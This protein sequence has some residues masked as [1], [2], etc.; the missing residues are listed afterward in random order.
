MWERLS[1][2][3]VLALLALSALMGCV[4]NL[5]VET[6]IDAGLAGEAR[7]AEYRLGPSDKI[8]LIIYGEPD[9]SGE[10]SINAH[11][12]LSLPLLGEVDAKGLTIDELRMQVAAGFS[13]GYLNDAQVAAEVVTYRPYYILGEVA[14]PG[15]YPYSAG[16]TVF[17]AVAAAQGFS[18]RAKKSSVY[19][20][21]ADEDEEINTKLT[22]GLMV[23]PGDVI[24]VGERFF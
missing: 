13:E 12:Q 3:P 6:A 4:S 17:K 2:Q 22:Q 14:L 19:I 8:R 21:R 10:F 7:L 9:L 24:R 1:L 5:P 20:R 15:E 16:I 23:Y 18:Y 11:G